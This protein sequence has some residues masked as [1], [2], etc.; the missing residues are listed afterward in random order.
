MAT[1]NDTETKAPV[2]A[3]RRTVDDSESQLPENVLAPRVGGALARV[4]DTS[5]AA[6]LGNAV[7]KG[8]APE[9]LEKLVALYERVAD[10][11]AAQEFS[12]SM[13]AFQAECPSIAKTSEAE[14]VT[15]SGAKYG[16]KYAELDE[17]ARTVRPLLHKHG[18]S[19]TW[20]SAEDKGSIVCSCIVRHANGHSVTAKFSCSID[21]A[22]AMSGAQ[23]SG[24]ALTYARRQA[25]IQALGL[26]TTDGDN[27]AALP[28]HDPRPVT[29]NQAAN[30]DALIDE[31]GA[32]RAKFLKFFGVDKVGLVPAYR[33]AEAVKMLEEKRRRQG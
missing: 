9:A 5:I 1:K 11:Q 32:D 16:Y 17:I 2:R 20:D 21:S 12:A 18:L 3:E 28:A 29:D 31:V 19:Y 30:L 24:A 15:R 23:K 26:T 7:E 4:P 27:D 25:L 8:M 13:A 14:I 6:I 33:F 10:R 22:A